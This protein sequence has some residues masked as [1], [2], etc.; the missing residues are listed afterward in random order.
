MSGILL[1]CNII[2]LETYNITYNIYIFYI[3]R[4]RYV[5]RFEKEEIKEECSIDISF[6][7][8]TRQENI[9]KER[10]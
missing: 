2:V 10:K 6:F 4:I 9:D 7:V 1:L 8:V 3:K 5:G